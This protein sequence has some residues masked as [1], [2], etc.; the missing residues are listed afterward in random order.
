MKWLKKL[1][2]GKK[3]IDG[4][5]ELLIRQKEARFLL[6]LRQPQLQRKSMIRSVFLCAGLSPDT[7]R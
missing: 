1:L 2:T 6:S 3:N 4:D 5:K 7:E